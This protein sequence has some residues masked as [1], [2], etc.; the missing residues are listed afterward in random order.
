[1]H[2][3][4]VG[5]ICVGVRAHLQAIFQY[6]VC[7]SIISPTYFVRQVLSLSMELL[8]CLDMTGQQAPAIDQSLTA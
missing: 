3:Y 4:V 7:S 8:D 6:Q 2:L 5:F 1:M